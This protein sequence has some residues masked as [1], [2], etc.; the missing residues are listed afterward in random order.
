MNN[1]KEVMTDAN[2]L[3]ESRLEARKAS[4]WKRETMKC[5]L[6]YLSVIARKQKELKD[7]VYTKSK[8]H[9]FFINERGRPRQVTSTDIA[10]RIVRHALCDN[11]LVPELTKKIIYNSGAS[12]KQRGTDFQ[13]KRFEIDLRNFY[14]DNGS[15]EGHIALIDFSKFYD[16]ILHKKL[17][18]DVT[19]VLDDDYISWIFYKILK[20]FR[21]DVSSLS[22]AE[23][24]YYKTNTINLLEYRKQG[25]EKLGLYYL[26]KS[27]NIG[28]QTSQISGNFYAHKIDN[29]IKI[30]RGHKGYGRYCDDMYIIDKDREKLK[31]TLQGVY[32]IAKEYGIHINE[33]KTKIVKLSSTF[34]FLKVRY[35]MTDKGKLIKKIDAKKITK[36]K[37]KLR[38][39]KTKLDNGEVD[40]KSVENC[41]KSWFGTHK[42]Y[43]NKK[44]EQ[45]L[46]NLYD[47]LFINN[48]RYEND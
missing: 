47:E 10:S 41:F 9:E 18:E 27:L 48:W 38:K 25:Y 7:E 22:P 29:Y 14:R 13:R 15:N 11:I 16:N 30:V 42:K 5:N 20:D 28:D 4:A 39:L 21:I 2:V 12:I 33:S 46:L 24:K 31:E 26:N 40:Y 32:K 23:R 36:Q 17:Y 45:E 8:S 44:Q 43:M 1:Y 34:K 37:R 19:N 35:R 6:D 3:Y